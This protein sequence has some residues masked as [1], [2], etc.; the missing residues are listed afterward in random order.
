[1]TIPW[2]RYPFTYLIESTPYTI[3][4]RDFPTNLPDNFERKRQGYHF[5]YHCIH[6]PQL[7]E[8]HL[9]MNLTFNPSGLSIL[10]NTA[11][12][13]ALDYPEE[14]IP[15]E[16]YTAEP[17]PNDNTEVWVRSM[18]DN[19]RNINYLELKKYTP[20]YLSNL[21][22]MIPTWAQAVLGQIDRVVVGTVANDSGTV[23]AIQ[24]YSVSELE[25]II[26]GLNP[27]WSPQKSWHSLAVIC[28]LIKKSIGNQQGYFILKYIRSGVMELSR[29]EG[30]LGIP[31]AFPENF[32]KLLF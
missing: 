13:C 29:V 27:N 19:D 9:L 32:R 26:K 8:N 16:K 28:S 4:F 30:N 31:T 17:I 2:R 3:I 11:P 25:V 15:T 20:G 22:K 23:Q 18:A 6:D 21:D 10:Y 24:E 1:M 14:T 5:E 12:D 7:P